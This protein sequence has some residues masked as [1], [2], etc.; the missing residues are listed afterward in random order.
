MYVHVVHT[1][2]LM[3]VVQCSTCST[4]SVGLMPVQSSKVSV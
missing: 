1:I 2:L 4:V 3:V